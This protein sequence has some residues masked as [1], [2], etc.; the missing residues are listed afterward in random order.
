MSES[1]YKAYRAT[2]HNLQQYLAQQSGVP[3]NGDLASAG[4]IKREGSFQGYL[5]GD[6]RSGEEDIGAGSGMDDYDR[7]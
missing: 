5:S 2:Q 4:R 7:Y 3:F 1:Q 6:D